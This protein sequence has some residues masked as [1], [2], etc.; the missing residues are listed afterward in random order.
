MKS[1]SIWLLN[2]A[3]ASAIAI[4]ILLTYLGLDQVKSTAWFSERVEH[5]Y[6]TINE[7]EQLLAHMKEAESSNR[8]YMITASETFLKTYKKARREYNLSLRRMANLVIDNAHQ[9]RRLAIFENLSR[10]KWL[11]MDENI[12]LQPTVKKQNLDANVLKGKA[13][14]DAM[15][16]V[17]LEI[18]QE[19]SKLLQSRL[20]ARQREFSLAPAYLLILALLAVLLLIISAGMLNIELRRRRATQK[21][22]EKKIEALNRSN[23]ELEQFAYIASHDLQEPLRKIRAF[24]DRLLIRQK[25]SLS[26]DGQTMLDK[27]SN[28]AERMQGLINDLLTYSRMVS[29]TDT[30][31]VVNLSSLL[32]EVKADLSLMISEKNAQIDCDAL[33]TLLVYP[34]QIRQLFLNLLSNALKF[35][36]TG[37]NPRVRISYKQVTGQEIPNI[38]TDLKK[39]Q[40]YHRIRISDNGIGFEPEY[41][42]KIFIIFQRL[43]AKTAYGGTG[44]GL[45]ICRRVVTNHEGYI[46]AE[47]KPGEGAIFTIYFPMETTSQELVNP[48]LVTGK[49]ERTY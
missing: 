4:L 28:A 9:M 5:T 17:I 36:Q 49:N 48:V 21:D 37:I 6:K 23:A 8:G 15:Q 39:E 13:I 19:E 45:A 43:H 32:E 22:L 29:R 3:A 20:K 33:P 38:D 16:K 34:T 24:A 12:R 40:S 25:D 30:A 41:A 31:Q 42:E 18:Q 27:I 2:I 1:S 46:F 7:S 47:G 35:Q 26:E 14:M 10:D 11:T 44:I